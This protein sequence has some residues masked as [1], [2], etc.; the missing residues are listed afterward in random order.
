MAQYLLAESKQEGLKRPSQLKIV[1][2][3]TG[4]KLGKVWPQEVES[5]FGGD[6]PPP[7][8]LEG[9]KTI[10]LTVD[11]RQTARRNEKNDNPEITLKG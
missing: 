6:M 9:L 1:Q 5:L 7:H 2:G 4:E 10:T 8:K 3:T 11:G